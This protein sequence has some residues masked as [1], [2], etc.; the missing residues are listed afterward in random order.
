[1]ALTH[2]TWPI[3]FPGARDNASTMSTIGIKS[4]LGSGQDVA[5]GLNP[6]RPIS[7]SDMAALMQLL[8]EKVETSIAHRSVDPLMEFVYSSM[9]EGSQF[10]AHIPIACRKGCSF[11]CK[12]WVDTSPPEVLYTVKKMP[13]DQRQRTI[14]AV[15]QACAQ[16]SG[17]PFN[18]RLG[19]VNPPCP[20]LGGDGACNVYDN[21][22]VAC[23][24]LVSTDVEAC[25]R[26]FLDGSDEG[27]PGLKVWLTLGDSYAR[28]LE[29]ALIHSGLAHQAREWNDSLS[30]ALTQAD[31]EERWLGGAD[32]FAG[33]AAS[34]A[35]PT[36][37][38]PLWRSI[39]Q[40]AFG[41][42][43]PE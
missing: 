43:P 13:P 30:L 31:A 8:G 4:S 25:K 10:I 28:A 26:T 38:N 16:T 17:V 20:M 21:R 41:A 3:A 1:M 37:D 9:T 6:A 14:E 5:R 40:Q 11:C 23:R 19:K 15:E 22:P 12:V 29:G 42:P 2:D 34:P 7:A 35:P 39:Y 32:V 36:F 18:D 24:T 27:F 33:V